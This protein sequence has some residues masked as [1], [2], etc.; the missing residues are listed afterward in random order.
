MKKYALNL[1]ATILSFE[2]HALINLPVGYFS[3]LALHNIT[4][5]GRILPFIDYIHTYTAPTLS[6][7]FLSGSRMVRPL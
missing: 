5:T 4:D 7:T 2:S 3:Y 1:T 6:L